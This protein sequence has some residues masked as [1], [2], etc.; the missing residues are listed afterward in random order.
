MF[1]RIMEVS[2]NAEGEILDLTPQVSALVRESGIAEGEISLFV[3]HSTAALTTIEH[4][5]GVLADLNRALSV[6]A[7]DSAKYAHDAKWRDGNGRSHVKAA[8]VGP[9]LLR[10]LAAD[11]PSGTR[12]KCRPGADHRVYGDR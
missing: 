2:T 3:Q 11:R 7:P 1:R 10:D 4:E 12:Y 6:L 9:T 8:L 5:P